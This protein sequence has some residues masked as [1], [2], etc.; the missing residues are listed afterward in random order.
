MCCGP[1]TGTPPVGVMRVMTWPLL[2]YQRLPS[3]PTASPYVVP[4]A[5]FG[6]Y[7]IAGLG[8]ATAGAP[9]VIRP[10]RFVISSVHQMLLS[11]P[12]TICIGKTVVG[13]VI[14]ARL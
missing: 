10:I 12:T 2:L 3:Q 13:A 5:V 8:A 6:K 4:P 14:A 11:G 9:G 1:V 7:V